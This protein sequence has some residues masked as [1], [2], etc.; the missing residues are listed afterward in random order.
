[1]KR[2]FFPV[3]LG[4]II[5]TSCGDQSAS[6]SQS[7]EANTAVAIPFAPGHF[8][9][10]LPCDDCTNHRLNV[11][12]W[13]TGS[14][15]VRNEKVG[16]AAGNVLRQ[17]WARWKKVGDDIVLKNGTDLYRFSI[18]DQNTITLQG[19]IQGQPNANSLSRAEG[20]LTPSGSVTIIG[21]YHTPSHPKVAYIRECASGKNLLVKLKPEAA[22]V[23]SRFEEMNI[24]VREGVPVE[25]TGTMRV[26]AKPDQETGGEEIM[27]TIESWS[28]FKPNHQCAKSP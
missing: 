20:I 22:D 5:L 25:V 2:L 19:G 26:V 18:Q 21:R 9:A 15:F 12:L 17:E 10:A 11:M 13:S 7:A 27:L 14:A 8:A 23:H 28:E 4:I 3:I 24:N 1:M 16:T 6:D